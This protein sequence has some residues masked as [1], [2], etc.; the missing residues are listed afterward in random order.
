[1]MLRAFLSQSI[2]HALVAAVVVEGLLRVWRVVDAAWRLRLRLIPLAVPLLWLPSLFVF[3]RF[4]TGPRFVA[5]GALFAG[6]R[7][8]LIAV[9]GSGLGDLLLLLSAGLGSALFLRDALPPLLDLLRGGTRNPPAAPW[10]PTGA[11]VADLARRHAAAMGTVP[12]AVRVIRSRFP[13][14]LCEGAQEPRL[15]VTPAT[16]ARLDEEE[17]EA[18]IAHEVAHAAHKDPAWGFALIVVRGL[19]FFNPAAQWVARALVD[20]FERRADQAAVRLTG[21]PEPLARAIVKLFQDGHPLPSD[22]DASFE[23]MF[24]RIRREAV[25][26]RC[27]R[28]SAGEAWERLDHGRLRLGL[29]VAGVL[30]L[31]FFVV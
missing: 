28:L 14:L 24:W 6:E 10:Q 12:P 23:R 9:R 26:R 20:D 30:G 8:N 25:E 4:R 1:V 17:L 27:R 18:A 29:A 3:A 13:A 22:D 2:L 11:L 7:W 31:V 16:V 21:R 5:S 19:L 15:V